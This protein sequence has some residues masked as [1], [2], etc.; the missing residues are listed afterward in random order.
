MRVLPTY[1]P[2]THMDGSS[3][4]EGENPKVLYL[5]IKPEFQSLL[6][7]LSSQFGPS[8]DFAI[9]TPQLIHFVLL[10][11]CC[12]WKSVRG[13]SSSISKFVNGCG[14]GGGC[15]PALYV[16]KTFFKCCCVSTNCNSEYN[17]SIPFYKY[18]SQEDCLPRNINIK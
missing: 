5:N 14:G 8:N 15:L 13:K 12:Q 3:C 4:K 7:C 16:G 1:F 6:V 10:F 11:C 17:V 2:P 18:P 9:Y